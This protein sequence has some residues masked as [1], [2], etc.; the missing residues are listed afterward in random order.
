MRAQST[1]EKAYLS[2]DGETHAFVPVDDITNNKVYVVL[3]DSVNGCG[4]CSTLDTYDV[5]FDDEKNPKRHM[6][7]VKDGDTYYADVIKM[8]YKKS[9]E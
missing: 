9:E 6:F 7:F 4:W 8:I 2:E 1:A 3:N 5:Y